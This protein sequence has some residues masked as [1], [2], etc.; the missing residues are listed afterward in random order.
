MH[1]WGGPE[2][3]MDRPIRPGTDIRQD[4]K[5]HARGAAHGDVSGMSGG[6]RDSGDGPT[7]METETDAGAEATLRK[8][9]GRDAADTVSAAHGDVAR[10]G[11]RD[12]TDK[13]A[14]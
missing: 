4:G 14:H 5:P 8:P 6:P 2:D 9:G 1:D 11:R 3:K 12:P 7:A 13:C 10:A